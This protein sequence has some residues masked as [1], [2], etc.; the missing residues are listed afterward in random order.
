MKARCSSLE[1]ESGVSNDGRKFVEV[2][3]VWKDTKM[4]RGIEQMQQMM[5]GKDYPGNPYR[6]VDLKTRCLL[7]GD[8]IRAQFLLKPDDTLELY[9]GAIC[10][11]DKSIKRTKGQIGFFDLSTDKGLQMEDLLKCIYNGE[12]PI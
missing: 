5:Q 10:N 6:G 12:Y 1:W 2:Y 3:G 11:P 8:I 9:W 7:P 4:K